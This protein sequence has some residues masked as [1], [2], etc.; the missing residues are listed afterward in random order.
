MPIDHV[1]LRRPLAVAGKPNENKVV[2]T[3]EALLNVYRAWEETGEPQFAL[4]GIGDK[5]VPDIHEVGAKVQDIE[6]DGE[7][8]QASII[9]HDMLPQGKVVEE[10]LLATE[11]RPELIT[12][13]MAV[14][15]TEGDYEK[16]EDGTLVIKSCMLKHIGIVKVPADRVS[17]SDTLKGDS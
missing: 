4:V 6:F 3:K 16:H 1:V 11:D 15:V 8:L 5:P 13:G 14:T 17:Q 2:Y 10:M 12:L 7:T 9:P